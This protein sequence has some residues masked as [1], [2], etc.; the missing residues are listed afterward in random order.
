MTETEA[1]GQPAPPAGAAG[2]AGDAEPTLTGREARPGRR[3]PRQR[4]RL[5]VVGAVLVAAFVYIL[6]EGLGSSLNYFD[7][8]DQAL[9]QK[10][11]LGTSTFRLEGVVVPG[12]VVRTDSGADFTVAEG[13]QRVTVRNTGTPPQLFQANLPV[14]VVGHFASTTSDTFLSNQ[15]LV[16]H[17]ASYIAAHPGRVKA[18]NGSV[19]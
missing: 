6:A 4:V 9:A 10:T 13:G 14:V 5:M 8:V 2:E 1:P 3:A 16:K 11:S 7:T 15:I 17:S 12:T 19:R 18:P